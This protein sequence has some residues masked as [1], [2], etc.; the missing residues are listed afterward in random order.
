MPDNIECIKTNMRVSNIHYRYILGILSGLLVIIATTIWTEKNDFTVYLT[1]I[2]TAISLVLGLVAIFYAFISNNNL[3]K[4]IGN[5]S[6]IAHSITKVENRFSEIITT[7]FQLNENSKLSATHIKEASGKI[8]TNL[9]KLIEALDSITKKTETLQETINT[10]PVDLKE[11]RSKIEEVRISETDKISSSPPESVINH[12]SFLKR[13]S[14]TGKFLL[15]YAYLSHKNNQNIFLEKLENIHGTS[16]EYFHG[17]IVGAAS[18]GLVDYD[19]VGDCIFTKKITA[20]SGIIDDQYER[21]LVE[22]AKEIYD[23]D[24]TYN[25][26][27]NTIEKTKELALMEE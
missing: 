5:I 21:D 9:N 6:N 20:I 25:N 24:V 1:N 17:Y 26:F 18:A 4:S 3:S 14:L 27:L 10:I 23:D 16:K 22:S 19:E 2:A 15:F 12:H 13:T 11:I 8:E 7:S